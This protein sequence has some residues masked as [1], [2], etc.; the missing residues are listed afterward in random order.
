MTYL[1]KLEG[2]LCVGI[3]SKTG[4]TEVIICTNNTPAERQYLFKKANFSTG[5]AV[6]YNFNYKP[7]YGN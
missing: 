3:R 1:S 4:M 2:M 7:A 5:L 6:T